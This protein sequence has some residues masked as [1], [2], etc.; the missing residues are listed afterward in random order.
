[1]S[2]LPRLIFKGNRILFCHLGF[3][4]YGH[5]MLKLGVIGLGNMGSA[6]T[7]GILKSGELA[8][9]DVAVF[10]RTAANGEKFAASQGCA[11]L[12]SAQELAQQSE[13]LLVAVKP[14][15][16]EAVL[17][18]TLAET[19]DSKLIISVAAGTTLD[20]LSKAAGAQHRIIRVMPNTPSLIGAGACGIAKGTNATDDDVAFVTRMMEAVGSA[21]LVTEDQLHAVVGVSGSG[22]AYVYTF[23]AALADGGVKAGLPRADAQRLAVQTV[24]GGARMVAETGS[25]P[26]S[27][28][29]AVASPGGTTIAAIHRLEQDGLHATVMNAVI[30]AAERS[31]EMGRE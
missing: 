9:S 12:P 27:L 25:H 14:Y 30:A 11:F 21:I 17:R 1:M 10:T 23:I 8:A 2:T 26:M 16:I 20:S 7:S 31:K 28:R 15:Q 24:L 13:R 3:Y 4:P 18:D 6:L 5:D 29:D 19:K 22:P